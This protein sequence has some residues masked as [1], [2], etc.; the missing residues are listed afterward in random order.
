MDT[1]TILLIE[2]DRKTA[3][4]IHHMLTQAGYE[5]EVSPTG[6]EGLITAWRDQP[7]VIVTETEL[8]DLSCLELIQK[9]RG[10]HRTQKTPLFGL[11]SQ[12][13][14]ELAVELM[15]AGID[16][17]IVK[18]ADAVDEL[19][20]QLSQVELPVQEVGIPVGPPRT[21]ALTIFL[22]V[23]GGVGTS[24]VCLNVAHQITQMDKEHNLAVLDLVLP[25]GSH[26]TITGSSSEIDL[27]YLTNLQLNELTPDF[28]RQHLPRPHGWGFHFIQGPSNPS[29]AAEIDRERLTS[30]L[31]VVRT[32]Y[33]HVVL[34][35]GR[36]LSKLAL[37]A[38]AQADVIVTVLIPEPECVA[39]TIA[40]HDFLDQ[41][42]IDKPLMLVV[43]N[44]PIPT[45]G[46]ATEAAAAA[47]G[48]EIDVAV[49]NMGT[50]FQLANSLHAPLL[51][52]FP[53]ERGTAA[54]D[55]IASKIISHA[56]VEAET[57]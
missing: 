56:Y 10:D 6:K 47:L 20:R 49:P 38:L 11:T 1:K 42:G 13:D 35:I 16:R 45:E 17:F 31:Q 57:D 24:S 15:E 55:R 29:R 7:D 21:G 39:N 18:Q 23:K 36:N 50:D 43:T 25:I 40:I 46:Y 33:D 52:R 37:V 32:S 44:R 22:G 5:V 19:F 8:P 2:P 34:D 9:L 30:V 48:R 12:S 41:E 4:F 27:N 51:L 3:N 14:P 53:D 54:L 26:T 28:V